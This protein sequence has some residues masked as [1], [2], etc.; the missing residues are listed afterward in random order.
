M[1]QVEID[2]REAAKRVVERKRQEWLELKAKRDK[3]VAEAN[4]THSY[5]ADNYWQDE[6]RAEAIY[7]S[8]VLLAELLEP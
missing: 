2:F 4:T 7:K 1:D 8:A 3:A 5:M 6:H